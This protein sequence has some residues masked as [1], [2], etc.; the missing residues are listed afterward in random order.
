MN[1]ILVIADLTE[2]DPIAIKQALNLAEAY[3]ASLEIVYFC[4]ESLRG[5][6]GDPETIKSKVIA[7]VELNAKTQLESLDLGDIEYNLTVVWEKYIANWVQSYVDDKAPKLVIKTGHRTETLFYTPTDWQLLR[8]C[9]VPFMIVA[10][11]KWRRTPNVL[12]AVDLGSASEEKRSLNKQVMDHAKMLADYL[13]SEMFVVYTVPYS[14]LLRDLGMQYMD[15][16]EDDAQK[17][18]KDEIAEL[19]NH[20]GI[21][22]THFDIKPGLPEKVIP[23]T[24]AKCKAGLVVMGTAGRKGLAGKF[25]G[26]TAEQVLRLLKSDVLALKP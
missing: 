13:G 24:A 10:E 12:A 9:Q 3:Q 1:K 25:I 14:T 16:L 7:T 26:N 22:V 8:E 5:V 6:S 17:A 20:Y 23:S 4:Y 2:N 18:H 21:P 19:A 15:E 11:E